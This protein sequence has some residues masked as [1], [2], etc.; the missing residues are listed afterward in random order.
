MLVRAGWFLIALLLL[1]GVVAGVGRAVF[2]DDIGARMEP[3]R[4]NA[5]ERMGRHDPS[6]AGRAEDVREFDSRYAAHRVMTMLHVVP[7][8][9]FLLL[10]SLQFSAAIRTRHPAVHRWM[11]RTLVGLSAVIT[12]SGVFFG[13][14]TP[15][16]GAGERI[17]IVVVALWF[18]TALAKAVSAIRERRVEAHRNWM[19]RAFAIVLGVST[20]RVAAAI[21]DLTMTPHGYSLESL[22][23]LSLVVGWVIA[24][25]SAELWILRTKLSAVS[26]GRFAVLS[27]P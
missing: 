23:V 15:F 21:I 5:F 22:F 6:A 20:T 18:V 24:V 10:V 19:I 13:L 14:V 8:T 1:L 26:S 25:C 4:R 2:P 11:G 12:V 3:Y 17:V 7:G 16:G 27:R 9:L